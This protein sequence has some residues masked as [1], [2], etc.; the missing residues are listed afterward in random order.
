MKRFR[1]LLLLLSVLSLNVH[2]SNSYPNKHNLMCLS[3]YL[4]NPIR[5]GDVSF[6]Y[7]DD[8]IGNISIYGA[9]TKVVTIVDN[10]Y[11]KD[12]E[13]F[14]EKKAYLSVEVTNRRIDII[15]FTYGTC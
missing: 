14:E 9:S 11:F 8:L 2:A 12:Q 3:A 5:V 7:K 6:Y 13:D 4:V 15:N 10:G 1:L